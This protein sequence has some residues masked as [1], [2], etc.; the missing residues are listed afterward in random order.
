MPRYNDYG[1]DASV[2][3]DA[4]LLSDLLETA[5][6]VESPRRLDVRVPD[7]LPA[8]RGLYVEPTLKFRL[9][10]YSAYGAI[11]ETLALQTDAPADRP[12]EPVQVIEF[13]SKIPQENAVSEDPDAELIP[14]LARLSFRFPLRPLSPAHRVARNPAFGIELTRGMPD[15]RFLEL[16][17]RFPRGTL[18]GL[19][20]T[21]PESATEAGGPLRVVIP[22]SE[23]EAYSIGDSGWTVA[24]KDLADD[25]PFPIITEGFAGG[26]SSVAILRMTS[27]EG[28]SFDRWVYHRFPSINQELLDQVQANGRPSRRDPD[29]RIDVVYIDASRLQVFI[30]EMPGGARRFLVR[31]PGRDASVVAGDAMTLLDEGA[32]VAGDLREMG[33]D[34]YGVSLA[35]GES[36]AHGEPVEYA[37]PV[38]EVDR[39]ASLIGTHAEAKLA[40]ELT[41][42]GVDGWREVVWLPF[43]RY[44][45]V[46][47][48]QA[49]EVELPTGQR[50][51]L[52]FGRVRHTF[53]RFGLEMVDFEMISYDH[54]G[55]PRDFQSIV[56]VVP[57][58]VTSGFDAYSRVVKLNAP[59]RAPHVWSEDRSWPAN[60][61][62]MAV[63][64][65]DSR[66]Y[67]LSQAGWD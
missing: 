45:G 23:G 29:P 42:E 6:P 58:S 28:E 33:D 46:G 20:V 53:E 50:V 35:F 2:P 32:V 49:R 27:P 41:M 37:V 3:E 56:R 62:L 15:E 25:P 38:P 36:W 10:G 22:A 51:A 7:S 13:V 60:A 65:V 16:G 18:H 55:A 34:A 8:T 26:T 4:D 67:K 66:A 54:R 5:G 39:D 64:G 14:E 52:A 63:R 61:A 19:I 57:T 43:S 47:G 9:V 1:L 21:V 24:V 40:V 59:L 44:L 48:Q 11:E 12:A 17:T 30:D 31:Q